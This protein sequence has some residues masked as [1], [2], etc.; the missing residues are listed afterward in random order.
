MTDVA[1]HHLNAF[2]PVL[3][4][5]DSMHSSSNMSGTFNNSSLKIHQRRQKKSSNASSLSSINHK[6][7]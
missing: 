2:H 3:S 4:D 7:D 6:T 5:N 1:A